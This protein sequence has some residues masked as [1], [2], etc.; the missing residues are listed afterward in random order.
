MSEALT[1]P[2]APTAPAA[3]ELYAQVRQF[4]A[5]Q[6][7]KLDGDDFAGFAATF[8]ADGE[9]YLANGGLLRGRGSI[10]QG[11]R[12]A[13]ARFQGGQPRHWFDM[14]IVDDADA[15][16]IAV[17]YY[18]MVSITDQDAAVRLEPSCLVHD[19]LTWQGDRLMIASRAIRRD[20]HI[21]A[22]RPA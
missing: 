22:Q 1:A 7:H 20:D 10:E 13:A 12:A 21:A 3:A 19:T 8:T 9:F 18:A 11:A 16:A 6:M 14:L 4:Y 5:R 2:P 17:T 15:A